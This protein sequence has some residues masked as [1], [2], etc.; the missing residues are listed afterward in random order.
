MFGLTSSVQMY[1]T[2]VSEEKKNKVKEKKDHTPN[3]NNKM[4]L[5]MESYCGVPEIKR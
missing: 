1:M 5:I 2:S 3:N 4:L